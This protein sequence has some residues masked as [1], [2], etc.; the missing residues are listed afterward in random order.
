MLAFIA[1]VLI[2]GLA[3]FLMCSVLHIN[4][5]SGFDSF[6]H[7]GPHDHPGQQKATFPLTDSDGAVVD[8]DRRMQSDRRLGGITHGR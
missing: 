4:R 6:R 8:S 2:G 1:G 7:K 5:D 3:G